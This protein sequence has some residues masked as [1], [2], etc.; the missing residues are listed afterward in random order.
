MDKVK[1]F[2]KR[3]V[4]VISFLAGSLFTHLD[5]WNIAQDTYAQIA[6]KIEKEYDLE[7]PFN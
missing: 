7:V 3:H 6:D 5:G 1:G 4:I 2:C